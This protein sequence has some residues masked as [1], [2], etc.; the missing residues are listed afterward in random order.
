MIRPDII[1]AG[2][3]VEYLSLTIHINRTIRKKNL[4]RVI[5]LSL[6][7][8]GTFIATKIGILKQISQEIYVGRQPVACT[9]RCTTVFPVY[10]AKVVTSCIGAP[11]VC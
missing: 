7:N 11:S 6:L 2:E 1:Q 5:V 4:L 8:Y 3:A 9:M 10:V